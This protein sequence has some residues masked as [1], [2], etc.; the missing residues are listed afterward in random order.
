MQ[1]NRAMFESLTRADVAAIRGATVVPPDILSRVFGIAFD[2][3]DGLRRSLDPPVA[4]PRP[5][6]MTQDFLFRVGLG[7]TSSF[8]E[9]VR[10]GSE[11]SVKP[12]KIRNDHVDM[13]LSVYGTYFNGV[14]TADA[15]LR[16][17]HSLNRALLGAMRVS[18]SREYRAPASV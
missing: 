8:L 4:A 11:M 1:G 5:K 12:E 15:K 16:R 10:T 18:L 17:V 2:V 3:A 14:M 7:I 9:W 13:M 6:D